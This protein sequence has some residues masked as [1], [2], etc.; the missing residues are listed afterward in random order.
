MAHIFIS[1][2]HILQCLYLLKTTLTN[3]QD[4]ENTHAFKMMMKDYMKY[5]HAS[6]HKRTK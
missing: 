4:I 1:K 5:G 2:Y 6:L 3:Y